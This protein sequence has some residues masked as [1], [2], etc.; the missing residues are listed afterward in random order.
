MVEFL[1]LFIDYEPPHGVLS[2]PENGTKKAYLKLFSKEC[3][4]FSI[5]IC[6]QLNWIPIKHEWYL[7]L[8]RPK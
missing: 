1:D 3:R 7:G 5:N 4:A 6:P 8:G 2:S